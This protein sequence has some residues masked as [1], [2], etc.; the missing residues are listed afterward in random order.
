MINKAKKVYWQHKLWALYSYDHMKDCS[1][2]MC[3]NPR[4]NPWQRADECLTMQERK[5][6]EDFKDQ[7]LEMQ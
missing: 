1:C 4:H 7:W 2:Y 6:N 3:G 5:S